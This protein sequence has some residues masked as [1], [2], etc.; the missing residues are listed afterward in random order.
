MATPNLNLSVT[1]QESGSAISFLAWRLEQDGPTSSNMQKIDG[2]AGG[3]SGSITSLE[4]GIFFSASGSAVSANTYGAAVSGITSYSDGLLI[5]LALDTTITGT[6]TL[7]INGLGAVSLYKINSSGADVNLDNGDLIAGRRNIFRYDSSG[8]YWLWVNAVAPDQINPPDTQENEILIYHNNAIT[9]GSAFLTSGSLLINNGSI[10]TSGSMFVEDKLNVSGSIV[11]GDKLEV[12][13]DSNFAKV[14]TSGSVVIGDDLEVSGSSIFGYFPFTPSLGPT[15]DY[16]VTNKKYVDD[17]VGSG[18][19]PVKIVAV[20]YA[21]FTGTQSDSFG[22]GATRVISGLSILHTMAKTTNKLFL[23]GQVGLLAHSIQYAEAGVAFSAD[24]T[25]I[26]VGTS[27]GSRVAVSAVG[28]VSSTSAN[29]GLSHFIQTIYSPGSVAEITYALRVI[30]AYSS[31][32]TVYIN[33][34]ETDTDN[35]NYKRAVS[36]L[37]LIEL[38]D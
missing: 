2:W 13:G 33:R 10:Q 12:S 4:E 22:T 14:I 32:Q 15:M 35:A 34:T 21:E 29:S 8:G 6:V 38:E 16:H 23:L 19:S 37:T 26:S 7:D 31:T 28:K 27:S 11:G 18:V 30:N 17:E 9:S 20:E 25:L 3:V 36:S 1:S 5:V 24:A